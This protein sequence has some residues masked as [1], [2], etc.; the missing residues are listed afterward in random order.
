MLSNVMNC[1][2]IVELSFTSHHNT[3]ESIEFMSYCSLNTVHVH[4]G[5]TNVSVNLL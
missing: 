5:P 1:W 4:I 2:L 3:P